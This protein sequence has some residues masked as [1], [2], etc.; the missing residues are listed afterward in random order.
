MKTSLKTLD[1]LRGDSHCPLDWDELTGDDRVRYCSMCGQDVLN[2]SALTRAEA[3][4]VVAN[5]AVGCIRLLRRADGTAVTA[6]PPEYGGRAVRLLAGVAAAILL[7]ITAGCS[8]T[9]PA[10]AK[11]DAEGYLKRDENGKCVQWM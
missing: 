7:A 6:D 2:L 1:D 9:A 10:P 11:P 5:P 3:E 4:R 8:D